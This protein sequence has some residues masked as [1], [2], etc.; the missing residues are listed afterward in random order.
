MPVDEER[1]KDR[2]DHFGNAWQVFCRIQQRYQETPDDETCRMAL[3]QAFEFTFELA[4]KTMKD[5]L[6]SEGFRDLGGSKQ[7]IR[8]AYQAGLIQE[9]EE[10]M[11]AVQ[12][13]NLTTHIYDPTIL[14]ESIEYITNTFFLLAQKLYADLKEK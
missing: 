7:T 2:F 14:N 13:R 12:K 3:V 6:E 1:W 5:Y 11:E 9:A 8:N 10:W 4:W